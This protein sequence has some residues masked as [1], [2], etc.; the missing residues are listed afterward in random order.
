MVTHAVNLDA[1]IVVNVQVP[2]LCCCEH[3]VILQEAYVADLLLGLELHH[4][5]LPLPVKHREVAFLA[6]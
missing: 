6:S 1:L 4:E 2:V 3:G 5:V